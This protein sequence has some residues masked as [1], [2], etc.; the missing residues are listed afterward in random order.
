M[1]SLAK[2]LL[3]SL[4]L[5]LAGFTAV[6]QTTPEENEPK[7][8]EAVPAIDVINNEQTTVINYISKGEMK[9]SWYGP[10]FHGRTTA[11]GEKFDQEALTAA[12]KTLRFGT[13]LRLTNPVTD[14]S[15]IVRINDRG[16]YVRGRNIDVSKEAAYELGMMYKGLAKLKVEQVSLK[17]VNFPAI[18]LN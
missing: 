15:V 14:K 3:F 6:E 1:K 10:R 13:L 16:P 11:N 18:H 17:G 2:V 5:I 4:L 9:A 8:K 7:L 12:H